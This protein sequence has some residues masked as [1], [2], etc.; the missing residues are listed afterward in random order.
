MSK[1]YAN[2]IERCP[3]CGGRRSLHRHEKTWRIFC[4]WCRTFWRFAKDPRK[5]EIP[6][7]PHE[8]REGSGARVQ[9]SLCS[10]KSQMREKQ[11]TLL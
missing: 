11:L 1:K 7:V 8:V 3:H 5:K 2:V 9:T 10:E 4:G 6:L